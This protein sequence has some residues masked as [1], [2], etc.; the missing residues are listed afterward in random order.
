MVL[1]IPWGMNSFVMI[2][3]LKNFGIMEISIKNFLINAL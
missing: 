3:L 2:K 1:L